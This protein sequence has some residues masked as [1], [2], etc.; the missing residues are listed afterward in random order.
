MKN[1]CTIADYDFLTRVL[2]LNKSLKN[3]SSNYTLHLL[4]LD[5]KI[6]DSINDK[7]IKLYKIENLLK[8]EILFKAKNNPP[9]RE[10]ILN[11]NKNIEKAKNL[12]FIW[13]LSAYFTWYCLENLECE[14]VL[15]IDS[16]IYFFNSLENLYSN[17]N[18]VS[19][20]IV[21]HRCETSTL[22]GKYNVGI[23]YFKNDINGYK[24]ATWWK[25]CLLFTDHEFYMSH[26][27]CGDQK[28]LE[29]FSKLFSNVVVLDKFIGHLAP[30]NF[31]E[32]LY[33]GKKIIWRGLEQDLLYCHFSNFKPDFKNNTYI[34][35]QRHG[36]IQ[37][38]NEYIKKIYDTY[39]YTLKEFECLK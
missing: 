10:A 6:Y 24:C 17:L 4:C 28:Y 23:V 15:Y 39:F 34:P 16:D 36:I 26:G 7:N 12:Q 9:S 32:H 31:H 35:A 20:G 8:D 5:N 27:T 22:N 38:N 2:A 30:W 14:D 1:F 21:E 11:T 37:L 3:F 29:L 19:V 18:N 33:K 25:N 13:S